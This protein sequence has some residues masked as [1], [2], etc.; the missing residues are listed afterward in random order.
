MCDNEQSLGEKSK[1][2]DILI[3]YH[4]NER[5]LNNMIHGITHGE[6]LSD[7]EIDFAQYLLKCQY[8]Q[9]KGLQSTL[10]QSKKP[11]YSSIGSNQIQI[12]HSW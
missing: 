1:V 8:P 2:P 7:R 9:L 12:I 3:G 11:K 5:D 6:K 10:L 4:L